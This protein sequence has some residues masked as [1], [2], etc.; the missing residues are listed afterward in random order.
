MIGLRVYFAQRYEVVR[1]FLPLAVGLLMG[2][3]GGG[4]G[5]GIMGR[6]NGTLSGT[7]EISSGTRVDADTALDLETTELTSSLSQPISGVQN[8][9]SPFPGNV[10]A[11]GYVSVGSGDYNGTELEYPQDERDTLRMQLSEGQ[12][13]SVNFF[14]APFDASGESGTGADPVTSLTLQAVDGTSSDSSAE[15]TEP[16]KSVEAQEDGAHNLIIEAAGGGPARYVLRA[17]SLSQDETLGQASTDF[18]PGEAIITTEA[19]ASDGVMRAQAAMP[20]DVASQKSL[21]GAQFRVTMP[22]ERQAVMPATL[23]EAGRKA[24]TLEWIRELNDTPGVA[25]AVPNHRVHTMATGS[26]APLSQDN[27]A[28]QQW[29]YDRINAVG[30]WDTVDNGGE[31]VRVAVL[32]TGIAR[33]GDD[34]HPD[35]AP[36]INCNDS[37]R[38][39][40]AVDKDGSDPVD[41]RGSH[42]T[43]VTG[44]AAADA[45]GSGDV[46]G[47]AHG[48][49]LVP[50]RVLGGSEGTVADVI[51]GVRWVVNN[52]N[53]RADVINLSLGSQTENPTL[54]DAVAEASAAGILVVAASGN[55]GDDRPFYPA[56]FPSV[57]SVGAVDCKGSRSSFSN[58]GDWLDL[59]A[60]GGGN[61]SDCSNG[62]DF[63]F[64]AVA[65]GDGIDNN[66]PVNGRQGTSMASPHVAGVLALMR[67]LTPRVEMPVIRALLREGRLT[68]NNDKGTFDQEIGW[69]IVDAQAAVTE[70][71]SGFAALAPSLERLRLDNDRQSVDLS[72]ARV[73]DGSVTFSNEDVTDGDK[74]WLD[75]EA[76]DGE[77]NFRVSL[78][79]DEMDP[80]QFFRSTLN[81]SY[82]ANGSEGRQ[83]QIPVTATLEANESDRN[84]GAHFVQLIPADAINDD[85]ISE[86]TRQTVAEAED[87]RYRFEFDVSDIEPGEY[88]LIA[89]SDL[90]NDGSFCG[91]GEACAEFPVTGQPEAIKITRDTS[92]TVELETAFT[93]PVDSQNGSVMSM[94][95]YQRLDRASEGA[96]P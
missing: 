12:R 62:D 78:N 32:D 51:A 22:L 10:I 96:Q 29:H 48:A 68:Q 21:G 24:E 61:P 17:T 36:N 87:G 44:I 76:I 4:D 66:T 41:D 26:T 31:S 64:S 59:A 40:D 56:A 34:W 30:A 88:F 8:T 46:T 3:C 79:T 71:I 27:Y 91:P 69:G 2:G 47:V 92:K 1:F 93:R 23:S 35:L 15:N 28:D 7:V 85:S 67:E 20:V 72:L 43:H 73:G 75:V 38:C 45:T 18:V 49:S 14:P 77:R 9:N 25:S 63:V 81:V 33:I 53:P 94:G 13:V 16:N 58:F 57:L 83:Y 50:V 42:G 84:A 55:A 74:P 37:S 60:P 52:G 6:Q 19:M 5:E 90:D 80:G 65:E 11:G 70:D 95:G 82:T 39:F 89:G 86:R 54:R